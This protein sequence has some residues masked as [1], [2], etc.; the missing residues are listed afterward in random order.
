M[1][2]RNKR[3][4]IRQLRP[5]GAN[6]APKRLPP[7]SE[8]AA[9]RQAAEDAAAAADS[10]PPG[11]DLEAA[12]RIR[13]ASTVEDPTARDSLVDQW[14]M[15]DT[16]IRSTLWAQ[17]R[18]DRLPSEEVRAMSPLT[19]RHSDVLIQLGVIT[20]RKARSRLAGLVGGGGE[21]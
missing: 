3:S 8:A 21:S 19:K 7:L 18:G 2:R 16:Q 13:R 6:D 14:L 4:R 11:P 1:A 20:H 10:V 9:A 12:E 17:R 5:D 15:L